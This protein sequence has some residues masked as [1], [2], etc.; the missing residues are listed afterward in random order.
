MVLI[1]F[2]PNFKKRR[3]YFLYSKLYSAALAGMDC[4]LVQVETDVSDGLPHVE[5][6]GALSPE[7]REARERVRTAIKNAGIRIPPKRITINLSPADRRKEGTGFDLAIAAGILLALELAPAAALRDAMI[8]G[9]VSL[10][11]TVRGIRGVLAM[12]D[13]AKKSGM[14]RL[15][16]PAENAEEGA[17][18][19]GLDVIAVKSVGHLLA[20]LKDERLC[21]PQSCPVWEDCVK[22]D[23]RMEE[24]FC[25]IGGQPVL[26]RAAEVACA[27]MHNL[28]MVGSA[29]AGKSMV[30]RRIPTILP[31]LSREESI[32]ISTIYSIGGC[33]MSGGGLVRQRPFRSPHHTVTTAGLIGGGRIPKPGEVSLAHGGVLFLDELP[34]FRVDTLETLRQPMED[35]RLTLVRAGIAYEFPADFMLVAAMNPCRCGFYPDRNLCHCT[36]KEIRSYLGRI[37]RPLL[38]RMDICTEVTRVSYDELQGSGETSAQIRSRVELVTAIQQERFAG[39]EILFNSRIPAAMLEKYCPLEARAEQLL[40]KVYEKR[41]L[42][43]RGLHSIRRVARTIADLDGKE[44]IGYEHVSEAIFYRGPREQIWGGRR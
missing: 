33:L 18:I 17:A 12:A 7:A 3:D 31:K 9:E 24:D 20:M 14:K 22:D 44:V 37:S 16:V 5:M 10:D 34:E 42:S 32:R 40:R 30:A 15:F 41:T 19:G 11:G 1:D 8:V 13:R 26:K 6:V 39:T 27:G 28:L 4:F 23:G 36:E 25:Q 29:G 2:V 35:R 21:R 38:D 43:T